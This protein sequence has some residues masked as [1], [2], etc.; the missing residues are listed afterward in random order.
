M[1]QD[2]PIIRPIASMADDL[3]T[4]LQRH[5]RA[6]AENR[7]FE[8]GFAHV[9]YD[10]LMR[11]IH[12]FEQALDPDEE[13]GAYLSSFGQSI[14]I[15]I[16]NVG[17]ANPYLIIF[18]GINV[19]SKSRVRLVQHTSQISVLFVAVKVNAAEARKPRRIGF[20]PDDD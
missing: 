11:E 18:D 12:E 1:S 8:Q 15:Q 7:A 2:K 14:F 19:D 9:I 3:E 10:K 13:I 17:Y 6:K 5:H 4:S 16:K 20:L